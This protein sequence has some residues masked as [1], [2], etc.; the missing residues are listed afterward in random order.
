[1]SD[2]S[3]LQCSSADTVFHFGTFTVTSAAVQFGPI[4][5]RPCDIASVELSPPPEGTA[6][7]Q[8][9]GLQ[10]ALSRRVRAVGAR[11]VALL[12]AAAG[13]GRASGQQGR[14]SGEN[15]WHVLRLVTRDGASFAM[16]FPDAGSAAEAL[17]FVRSLEVDHAPVSC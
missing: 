11:S 4:S 17:R 7:G 5:V 2:S 6:K 12:K 8:P 14:T 16:S 10:T 13:T 3:T 1:M 15:E 9:A